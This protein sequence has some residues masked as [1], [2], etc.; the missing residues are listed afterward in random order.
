MN[1]GRNWAFKASMAAARM[2]SQLSPCSSSS[3]MRCAPALLVMMITVF[4]QSTVLPCE[5]VSRPSSI[6]C[7]RM[8][9][10][11]GWAFSISSKRTTL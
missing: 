9:K 1:S 8:L 3:K 4:L 7:N 6:I 10:M 5:S 11:S 2:A